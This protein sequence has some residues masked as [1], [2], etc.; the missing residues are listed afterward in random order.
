MKTTVVRY[1]LKEGRAQEN[2]AFIDDVFGELNDNRPPGLRY[3][4]FQLE[5]ALTF[6]HIAVVEAEDGSNPL[7]ETVAFKKFVADLRGMT[8][9]FPAMNTRVGLRLICARLTE[10]NL[11]SKISSTGKNRKCSFAMRNT[12]SNGLTKIRRD[13]RRRVAR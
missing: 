1:K 13:T 6:V 7:P 12:L 11:S 9:S 5:D 3:V 8:S 10:S 2:R 4:S